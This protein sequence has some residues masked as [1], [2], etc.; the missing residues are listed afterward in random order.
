M[1]KV[2][3]AFCSCYGAPCH[4]DQHFVISPMLMRKAKTT[5]R[6]FFLNVSHFVSL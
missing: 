1:L 3:D 2:K 5:H 4:N 6:L